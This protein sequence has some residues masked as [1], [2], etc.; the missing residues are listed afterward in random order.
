MH[1]DNKNI[2]GTH[3]DKKL[4]AKMVFEHLIT[5]VAISNQVNC[6]DHRSFKAIHFQKKQAVNFGISLGFQ[7]MIARLFQE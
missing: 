1:S 6:K 3:F 4:L 5:I 2:K 7:Q